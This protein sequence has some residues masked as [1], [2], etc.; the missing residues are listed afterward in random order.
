MMFTFSQWLG[1]APALLLCIGI[2]LL[3]LQSL[4]RRDRHRSVAIT[5]LS[6]AAAMLLAA[7]VCEPV[8]LTELFVF[9]AYTRAL[10][11]LLC[12][13]GLAG[14]LLFFDAEPDD[15]SDECGL[16]L[17]LA[18]LG[19]VLLAAARHAAGLLLGLEILT[20]ALYGL[21]AW[22]VRSPAR[23][24]AATKYLVLSAASSATL[25]FGLAV[26]Y[27]VGGSA[28]LDALPQLFVHG[29]A[30]E[31]QRLAVLGTALL[32]AGLGF[33]LSLV[34][35][36]LWTAD[37]YQG[38]P[39]PVAAL[40][41]TL[42]KAAIAAV[43]LRFTAIQPLPPDLASLLGWVAAVTILAGAGAALLTT[44]L[45]R[46]LAYSSIANAGYLLVPFVLGGSLARES[47]L[48]FLFTYFPA[49]LTA[50]G[51]LTRLSVRTGGQSDGPSPDDL[52]GLW[53]R[54]PGLS[55][56]LS[57]ALLS[58]AGIPL[59]AGFV[60]KFYVVAAGVDGRAWGL[61]AAIVIGSALALYYYLRLIV[62]MFLPPGNDTP[63]DM[64]DDLA[65]SG[66][67]LAGLSALLLWWGMLPAQ[68]MDRLGAA[69]GA[70][71]RTP[72]MHSTDTPWSRLLPEPSG[73]PSATQLQ[74]RLT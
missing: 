47:V 40:L 51:V 61:V 66:L 5:I 20:V 6:L 21:I 32:W 69:A 18:V 12:G 15:G 38:A 72:A 39:L 3:M 68:L 71:R 43:L 56:C 62:L 30:P 70:L 4:G 48:F 36:H 31:E 50:F 24:E 58:L 64:N 49:S 17:L 2:A 52:R 60:G 53:Q 44:N 73:N 10:I 11:V 9:D 41:A 13:A 45:K 42:S 23:I 29:A 54:R 46:L 33:K 19:G 34:P 22:P 27:L 67:L 25:L 63:P 74:R 55:L 14:A 65:G 37:V 59:T 28:R 7:W 16:L 1:L 35:F 8:E 57:L 26:L